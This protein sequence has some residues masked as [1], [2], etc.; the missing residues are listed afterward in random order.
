MRWPSPPALP[1]RTP[2][3]G[4]RRL[5]PVA[6]VFNLPVLHACVSSTNCF[7]S[8]RWLA[9]SGCSQRTEV[10]A[11]REGCALDH[12]H[13]LLARGPATTGQPLGM[14]RKPA[15]PGR[16]PSQLSL[17]WTLWNI[18]VLTIYFAARRIG[19]R[20]D[21]MRLG[22]LAARKAHVGLLTLAHAVSIALWMND[23]ETKL[24]T[25]SYC[26]HDDFD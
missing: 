19:W 5:P 1:I 26:V 4:T 14:Y 10:V 2:A 15:L 9:R 22:T 13:V 12:Q 16:Q 24:E 8:G 23:E 18:A 7:M 11:K 20:H 17:T 25:G 21:H 3:A 6:V